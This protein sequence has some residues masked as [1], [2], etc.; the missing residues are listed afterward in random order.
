MA[1]NRDLKTALELLIKAGLVHKVMHTAARGIPLG[2]E[3]NPK[4]FKTLIF[5]VGIYQ[6]LLGL[7]IPRHV[8]ASEIDLVNKGHLAEMVAGLEWAGYSN[9]RRRCALFYW[10]REKRGSSAEVDYIIQ[11]GERIVPV[12]IKAGTSGNMRSMHMFLEDRNLDLGIRIS[13]ENFSRYGK[14]VT[15]P[16][17]AMRNIPL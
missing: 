11:Q 15:C 8:T 4:R 10:H 17:Y 13:L 5:D 16:L 6:R 12:E 1:Y 3:V 7:D 2:A 14:I 9:P